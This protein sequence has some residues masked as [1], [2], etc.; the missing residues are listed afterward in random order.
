[1][2]DLLVFAI[3]AVFLY[4]HKNIKPAVAQKEREFCVESTFQNG[5]GTE[6]TNCSNRTVWITILSN[7]SRYLTSYTKLYFVPGMY[8]LDRYLQIDDVKNFSIRKDLLFCA[9]QTQVMYHYQLATRY[10]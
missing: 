6:I 4:I 8:H 5:M 3:T 2:K 7:P 9:Q 10:L 1:M